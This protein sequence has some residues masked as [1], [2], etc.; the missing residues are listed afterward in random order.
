MNKDELQ[1]NKETA[2][3]TCMDKMAAAE[4]SV[5]ENGFYS[6]EEVEE[7]LAK[8]QTCANQNHMVKYF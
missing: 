7:E 1:S 3:K 8:I 2:F 4:N 6:E 5:Q